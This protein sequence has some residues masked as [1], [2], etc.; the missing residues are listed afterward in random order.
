MREPSKTL[1]VVAD[2]EHARFLRPGPGDAL[3]ADVTFDSASAHQQS[4]DLR[5]DRPGASFHTGSSAHHGI[6]PQHDPHQLEKTR[7]GQLVGQRLNADA[8]QGGFERLV[9]VAPPRTLTAIRDALNPK[10]SNMVAGEV[11][12]D[13]VKAPDRAVWEHIREWV[14]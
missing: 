6:A 14:S 8:A 10:T 2:G 3:Y 11:A 7:F 12:K 9:L 1:I 5:S 4:S 13:L